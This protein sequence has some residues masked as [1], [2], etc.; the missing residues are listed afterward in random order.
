[1]SVLGFINLM[2]GQSVNDHPTS[3]WA[4]QC[5]VNPNFIQLP[6]LLSA[7]AS[8]YPQLPSQMIPATNFPGVRGQFNNANLSIGPA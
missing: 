8:S 1:M 2:I 7:T 4:E 5:Q 3:C 6:K